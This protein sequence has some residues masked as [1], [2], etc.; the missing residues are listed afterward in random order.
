MDPKYPVELCGS[1][2]RWDTRQR[3][4]ESHIGSLAVS[5]SSD[6]TLASSVVALREAISLKSGLNMGIDQIG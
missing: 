3:E 5:S 2:P 4:G 6:C 1:I